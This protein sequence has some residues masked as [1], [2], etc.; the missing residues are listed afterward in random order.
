[1][2]ESSSTVNLEEASSGKP[3]LKNGEYGLRCI[4]IEK[5]K[6]K[7]GNDML[8]LEWEITGPPTIKV[9]VGDKEVEKAITGL[10]VMD[11]IVFNDLGWGKLKD[12]HKA[13]QLALTFDKA[14]P[15]L[16][17]YIGKG[18]KA[19]LSTDPQAARDDNTGEA[20]MDENGQ[21]L[22]I[23]QYSVKRYNK[24]DPEHTIPSDSV[25]F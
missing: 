23:N 17:Q 4:A 12:L 22:V 2:S 1:M 20:M 16:K 19:A 10:K 14:N 8:Q 6:S 15:N 24:P 3:F 18:V 13:C 11:W 5:K 7:K 25:A 21:P 9:T